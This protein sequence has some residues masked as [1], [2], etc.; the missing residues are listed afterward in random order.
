MRVPERRDADARDQIQIAA[1][2]GVE[3]PAAAPA[4]EHHRASAI[5]LQHV[6]GFE[7]DHVGGERSSSLISPVLFAPSAVYMTSAPH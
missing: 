4:L 1:A 3:Q 5:D 7:R 2:V 6:L